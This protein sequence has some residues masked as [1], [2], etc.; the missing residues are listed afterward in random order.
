MNCDKYNTICCKRCFYLLNCNELSCIDQGNKLLIITN[1]MNII[2]ILQPSNFNVFLHG[3][4]LQCSHFSISFLGVFITI[5][6]SRYSNK[7]EFKSKN[8]CSSEKMQ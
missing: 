7:F 1:T 2:T 8:T 6:K 3:Y 5:D 4:F